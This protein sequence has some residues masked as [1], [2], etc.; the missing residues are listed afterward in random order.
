MTKLIVTFRNSANV[1]KNSRV[2]RSFNKA[3]LKAIFRVALRS[4]LSIFYLKRDFN[5]FPVTEDIQDDPNDCIKKC[6]VLN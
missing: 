6:M 5:T 3:A 2:V 1:P 4:K